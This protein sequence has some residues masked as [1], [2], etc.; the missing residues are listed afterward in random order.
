MAILTIPA[1]I[2]ALDQ[3]V[4]ANAGGVPGSSWLGRQVTMNDR[5]LHANLRRGA[6]IGFVQQDGAG[7]ST[8][9]TIG[10]YRGT[11]LGVWD[12]IGTP[13]I[14]RHEWYIRANIPNGEKFVVVPYGPGYPYT[15]HIDT[16]P[17]NVR[18]TI[19]GT[20]AVK[21]YGPLGP[22]AE[23]LGGALEPGPQRVGFVMFAHQQAGGTMP[24]IV[25]V[26][27]FD[28]TWIRC[29]AGTF[30]GVQP[31]HIRFCDVGGTPQSEWYSIINVR[32]MV[33]APDDT[34]DI[35]PPLDWRTTIGRGY[36]ECRANASAELHSIFC[37]ELP[38]A[39]DLIGRDAA[40]GTAAGM[41]VPPYLPVPDDQ[42]FT[43]MHFTHT[44]WWLWADN[45]R[46]M[47]LTRGRWVIQD[48]YKD[49]GIPLQAGAPPDRAIYVF[50]STPKE[51]MFMYRLV[52]AV[53]TDCSWADTSFRWRV[54]TEDTAGGNVQATDALELMQNVRV[55]TM[56]RPEPRDR[57]VLFSWPRA[58]HNSLPEVVTPWCTHYPLSTLPKAN[59]VLR[60]QADADVRIDAAAWKFAYL[61]GV[62]VIGLG[63]G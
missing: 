55:S 32:T 41:G 59:R 6:S 21:T 47:A 58:E 35:W 60:V 16:D 10:D 29:A 8:L 19:V 44:P 17:M 49:V 7:A 31:A 30:T 62:E 63:T 51:Q 54:T 20:G 25:S 43:K 5:C 52:F 2:N 4:Y 27:A 14:R 50:D 39:G 23:V 38:L 1:A 22:G 34:V 56:G 12:T 15:Y 24:G 46:H 61:R 9:P 57:T 48:R 36:I 3:A 26:L 53:K 13:G 37:R 11:D 18:T 45:A 42:V 28:Q 40:L 33:A